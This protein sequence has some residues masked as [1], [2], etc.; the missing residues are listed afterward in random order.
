MNDKTHHVEIR[1]VGLRDGLQ[2][3]S[4]VL[5]TAKKLEWLE[6]EAMAGVREMEVCS[7]VPPKLMPQFADSAAVIAHALS[8]PGLVVAALIPN[9]KGAERGLELG[10]D[11]LNFVLSASEAHNQAN[12]RR[13]TRDSV[14]E[15]GRVVEL[16]RAH[17]GNT[18]I[19][20]GISTAFGCTLQGD[21]DEALVVDLAREL[22]AMGADELTVADTVGYGNPRAVRRVFEQVLKVAAAV[23]V[24]AHFHD[25]RGLGVAHALAA[26]DVG[27][28]HFDAALAGLGGCPHA[29]GATGNV[30]T[31]DLVFLME[32][33][34]FGTGIDLGALLETRRFVESVLPG[35]AM[36]GALARA[37]LPRNFKQH[38]HHVAAA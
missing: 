4:S 18:Q 28:R 25:T 19:T 27:V 14:A 2:M 32:S 30:N 31:E 17:G 20:C 21:V 36:F 10:V 1:E 26:L 6:R 11:K 9:L 34:G 12:L 35:E 33:M 15:F 7:F 29:P 22:V 37:G 8:I 38:T 13:S 5:P 24:A 16:V 3:V 23:P